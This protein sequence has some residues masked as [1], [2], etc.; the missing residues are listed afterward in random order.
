M[1]ITA[2]RFD[3]LNEETNIGT[4]DFLSNA[5]SSIFNS[6]NNELKDISADMESFLMNLVEGTTP[7]DSGTTEDEFGLSRISKSL[8]GGIKDLSTLNTKTIDNAI[9]GMLPDNPIAQSA[10]RQISSQCKNSALT[11]AGFGMPFD[12]TIACGDNTNSA[13]KNGCSSAQFSNLLSKMTN[14]AYTSVFTDANSILRNLIGLSN[15]GYDMNMCGVFSALASGMTPNMTSGILNRASAVLLGSLSMVGNSVGVMD[16]ASSTAGL[17]P[18]LENPSGISSFFTNFTKPSSV[19]EN[20]FSVFSDRAL[21][22]ATLL[23]SGWDTSKEDSLLSIAQMGRNNKDLEDVLVSKVM[24][25]VADEDSLS[26][27][28]S[29]DTDFMRAAYAFG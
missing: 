27:I 1:T 12:P 22:A 7:S 2:K 8:S 15:Y 3:G 26:T 18:I 4:V 21:A 23:D 24:D 16:L 6:P 13:G 19:T 10:F 28:F 9:A 20:G 14:G 17:N 29:S 11:P 25:N 5:S